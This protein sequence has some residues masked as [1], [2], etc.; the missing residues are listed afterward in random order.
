MGIRACWVKPYTVTSPN[1]NFSSEL[2]NILSGNFSPKQPNA[3]WCA[4]ITYISTKQGFVYLSCILDLYSKKIVSWEL[5]PTLETRYVVNAINKAILRSGDRPKVIHTDRGVQYTSAQ[6][7][8]ETQGIIKSC[9]SK[10]N[11]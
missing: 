1:E 6:Y 10:A 4:D 8:D 3:V 11:P 7:Y 5:A 2:K 9:P